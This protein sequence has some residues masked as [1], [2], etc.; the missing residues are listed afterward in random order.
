MAAAFRSLI[1][2]GSHP[3]WDEWI[4]IRRFS[5]GNAFPQKS[6]PVWDEWIEIAYKTSRLFSVRSHPVWDEWIEIAQSRPALGG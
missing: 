4:E 1:S 2:S 6:H 3:V 5:N